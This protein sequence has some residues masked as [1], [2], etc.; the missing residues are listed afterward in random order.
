MVDPLIVATIPRC[1]AS[2][3]S[4]LA[5]KRD[6]GMPRRQ[7]IS[8][9]E[10]LDLDEHLRGEIGRASDSGAIV[11]TLKAFIK[12]SSAPFAH[13]LAWEAQTTADFLVIESLGSQEHELCAD[14]HAV[15]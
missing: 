1:I 9:G 2:W 11:Q 4:S 3:A 14:D 8:Q 6:S 7:G 15:L 10:S 12:E 5:L 13:D